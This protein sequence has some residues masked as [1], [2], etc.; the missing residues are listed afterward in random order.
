MAPFHQHQHQSADVASTTA[1]AAVST[2]NNRAASSSS[3]SCQRQRQR[4]R[5]MRSSSWQ[6]L[7][8]HCYLVAIVSCLTLV[9][10]SW[11]DDIQ[12]KRSITLGK[13]PT[14]FL[15]LFLLTVQLDSIQCYFPL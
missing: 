9:R 1:A 4:Q 6:Q 14:H 7:V 15:P 3:S 10:A 11:Q 13:P 5:Q 2:I 12:P 8:A